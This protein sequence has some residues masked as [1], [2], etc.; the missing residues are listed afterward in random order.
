MLKLL[1]FTEH[2]FLTRGKLGCGTWPTQAI[3]STLF[4]HSKV[5]KR[6]GAVL[7]VVAIDTR[8]FPISD[9]YNGYISDDYRY[10]CETPQACP[11]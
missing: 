11:V 3:P 9:G 5:R 1:I 7:F 6:P 2:W 4:T 10:L 8:S